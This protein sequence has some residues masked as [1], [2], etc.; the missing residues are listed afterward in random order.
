MKRRGW[1]VC[2]M[3]AV[4]SGLAR[5][6][7]DKPVPVDLAGKKI[8]FLGDSITQGGTYISM[9]WYILENEHPGQAFDVFPLGLSSETLSGLSEPNHAGGRFPRPCLF[10]RLGRLLDKVKPDVVFACYGINDGIYLPLDPERFQAY[11]DGVHRLI[12]DLKAAGVARIYLITPPIYDFQPPPGNFNY[13]TVMSAYATWLNGLEIPGVRVFDLHQR[14]REAREKRDTPFSRD[15]VHPGADG[16]WVMA[17]S[18]LEGLG[19]KVPA[20]SA[21]Q[22]EADPLYRAV[23]ALRKHRASTWMKHIGYTREKAFPPGP[24][25]DAETVADGLREKVRNLK[26]EAASKTP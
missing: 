20:V 14:M 10:E 25:G 21:A 2:L 24:L 12:K 19:V 11:Q 15:K 9:I 16:H 7:A 5:P 4:L 13:D 22:V 17:Q 26:P 3:L 23:D 8:A 1:Y 18:V 6:E